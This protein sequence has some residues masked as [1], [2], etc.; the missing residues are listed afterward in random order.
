MRK[1]KSHI[2][3][4]LYATARWIHR[5]RV[6]V[7]V[8]NL[9][10]IVFFGLQLTKITV[11]TSTES[12]LDDD[13]PIFVDYRALIDQYGRG[14]Q[15]L[16]VAVKASDVFSLDF[17]ARLKRL[18]DELAENLPYVVAVSSIVNA[19]HVDSESDMLVVEK[20]FESW[21]S[22]QAELDDIRQRAIANPLL[23]D[24]LYSRNFQFATI[25]VETEGYLAPKAPPV[26]V[27]DGFEEESAAAAVEK[28]FLTSRETAEIVT[29]AYG[30]TR[31]YCADDF[32][33]YISGSRAVNHYVSTAIMDDVDKFL[34]LSI[35]MIS[36]VLCLVFRSVIGVLIPVIVGLFALLSTI[37]MM[38]VFN[39]PLKLP[40]QIL[41]SFLI[42]IGVS[43]VVHIL[44]LFYQYNGKGQTTEEAIA[45][46]FKHS[47][48][49]VVLTGVTTA[50]GL[51]SFLTADL[52]WAGSICR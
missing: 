44:S 8:F 11:N 10:L 4:A 41:P 33:I 28:A 50:C 38:V 13:H 46:A 26:D 17:V 52:E 15:D 51:L 22:T 37:G 40:S 23:V 36:I 16:V 45:N 42:A 39:E 25:L 43:Y 21:P 6:K 5:N 30:I 48:L 32:Q 34:A 3:E 9:V 19:R 31:K 27:F 12:Y 24:T 20:L 47:G 35:L 18:H 29:T 7:L 49:A 14:K 2:D 1:I